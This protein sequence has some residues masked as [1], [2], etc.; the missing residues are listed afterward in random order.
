MKTFAA[1][2]VMISALFVTPAYLSASGVT[3]T[4]D[5]QQMAAGDHGTPPCEDAQ[6]AAMT[7]SCMI[8]CA[9][10]ASA[11]QSGAWDIAH[12]GFFAGVLVIEPALLTGGGPDVAR[13]P[14]RISLL[15]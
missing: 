4:A 8:Y 13:R 12:E 15:S 11:L 2:L 9:G 6:C 1:L 7:D 3:M 14:P 10:I 5:M